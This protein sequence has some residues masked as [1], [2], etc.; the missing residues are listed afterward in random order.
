MAAAAHT[1]AHTRRSARLLGSPP[2]ACRTRMRRPGGRSGEGWP[3]QA[4][5]GALLRTLLRAQA[6]G[7]AGR[8]RALVPAVRT[9]IVACSRLVAPH[10]S[11]MV[12][13]PCQKTRA[14]ALQCRALE[15]Q[16][17]ATLPS[18]CCWASDTATAFPCVTD[19]FVAQSPLRGYTC[20]P[21]RENMGTQ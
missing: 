21:T 12:M 6:A 11:W 13:T 19:F 4:A 20:A 16:L 7:V 18:F 17:W 3:T 5:P 10:P 15:L 8:W 1:A 14:Q 9:R 2:A